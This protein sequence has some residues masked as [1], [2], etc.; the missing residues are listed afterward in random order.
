[1][2]STVT[3]L[4]SCRLNTSGS[5]KTFILF[6]KVRTDSGTCSLLWRVRVITQRLWPA[7]RLPFT[8]SSFLH[9]WINKTTTLPD[10][11]WGGF[12]LAGRSVLANELWPDLQSRRPPNTM[13][14]KARQFL[15]NI[16][17]HALTLALFTVTWWRDSHH[18]QVLVMSWG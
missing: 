8:N 11:Q 6:A 16:G 18:H 3:P 15:C 5:N 2:D 1:M 9:R 13:R 14:Y 7:T 17:K 4:V 12:S 10:S